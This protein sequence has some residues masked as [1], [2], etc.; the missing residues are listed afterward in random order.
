MLRG[1]RFYVA[2]RVPESLRGILTTGRQTHIRRS[3]HTSNEAEAIRRHRIAVAEIKALIESARREPDGSRK[4]KDPAAPDVAAEAARWREHLKAE[5]I[6]PAR[7]FDDVAFAE[8]IDK[9][10][11]EP[12]MR[13]A[14]RRA[15]SGLRGDR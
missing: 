7:A 4:G 14:V 5:G 1:G 9:V 2:V 10:A 8:T 11:G 15:K 6:A 3:L 13:S 12:L